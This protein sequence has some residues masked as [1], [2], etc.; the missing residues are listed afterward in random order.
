MTQKAHGSRKRLPSVRFFF[1]FFGR[2]SVLCFF[3]VVVPARIENNAMDGK[4][5]QSRV[6]VPPMDWKGDCVTKAPPL[7]FFFFFAAATSQSKISRLRNPCRPVWIC[8]GFRRKR[9]RCHRRAF[10]APGHRVRCSNP[11]QA[12]INGQRVAGQYPTPIRS[13]LP[14]SCPPPFCR[15]ELLFEYCGGSVRSQPVSALSA[16]TLTGTPF[17][18][19]VLD[20]FPPRGS[21]TVYDIPENLWM[22]R[23]VVVVAAGG[24]GLRTNGGAGS[25]EL[26]TREGRGVRHGCGRVVAVHS[27]SR[28]TQPRRAPKPVLPTG[29]RGVSAGKGPSHPPPLCVDRDGRSPPLWDRPQ[30]FRRFCRGC[31]RKVRARARDGVCA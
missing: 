30:L 14:T 4:E 29:W 18:G 21:P 1:L 25:S 3:N 13:P 10:S 11:K 31:R 5:R 24:P 2:L 6:E 9:R 7:L 8:L 19:R 15:A 17:V 26:P 27:K 23:R 16:E 28:L 12:S 22:V 20:R